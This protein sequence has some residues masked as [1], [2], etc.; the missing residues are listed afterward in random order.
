MLLL[1]FPVHLSVVFPLFNTL[2][3]WNNWNGLSDILLSSYHGGL[4]KPEKQPQFKWPNS[5]MSFPLDWSHIFSCSWNLTDNIITR[6][7]DYQTILIPW[8]VVWNIFYFPIYY[9]GNNNPKWLIFFRGL[10]NHQ[11]VPAICWYNSYPRCFFFLSR[12][13][14]APPKH[15]PVTL[16]KKLCLDPQPMVIWLV[17]GNFQEQQNQSIWEFPSSKPAFLPKVSSR[18]QVALRR[19][20]GWHLFLVLAAWDT[21]ELF[22]STMAIN[23]MG[24][25][26]FSWLRWPRCLSTCLSTVQAMSCWWTCVGIGRKCRG[27]RETMYDQPMD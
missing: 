20:R 21:G 17:Y 22:T 26:Y 8:L 24:S 15:T 27:I 25:G 10:A 11:P 3:G 4:L 5:G 16:P 14:Q 1:S 9:I 7:V 23:G 19:S 12:W 2:S 18:L 6:V 13:I